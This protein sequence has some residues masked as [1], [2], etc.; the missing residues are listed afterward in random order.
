MKIKLVTLEQVD[1]LKKGDIIEGYPSHGPSC[2]VFDASDKKHTDIYEIRSSNA[3][4]NMLELVMTGASVHMFS[5]PGDIGRLFIKSYNLLT[6]GIWW[7]D[8]NATAKREI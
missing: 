7:Y 6:D 4:N 8:D 1:A 2:D 3:N 5:S